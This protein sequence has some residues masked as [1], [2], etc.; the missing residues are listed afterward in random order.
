MNPSQLNKNEESIDAFLKGVENTL[1]KSISV[2]FE[3]V[4]ESIGTFIKLLP[5]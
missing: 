3:P 1:G 5:L 4:R 2:S